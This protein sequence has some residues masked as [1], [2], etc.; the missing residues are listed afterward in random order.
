MKKKIFASVI[1]ICLLAGA[2]VSALAYHKG[3][4]FV[5]KPAA[6][7]TPN[8]PAMMTYNEEE[9]AGLEEMLDVFRKLDSMKAYYF[10]GR[11][12]LTDPADSSQNVS[13]NF[14][15]ARLGDSTYYQLG[16]NRILS[17]PRVY[18]S[19]DDAVKKV[20][21]AGQQEQRT[22]PFRIPTDTLMDQFRMEGYGISIKAV[23]GIKTIRL[24]RENHITCKEYRLAY[25]DRHLIRQLYTR[26]TNLND[27]LNR[28][29]DKET[30]V[31]VDR[32]QQG[33]VPAGLLDMHSFIREVSGKIQPSAS[34]EGYEIVTAF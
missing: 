5:T 1:V 20:F 23:N 26:F 12:S 21:V 17:I 31:T 8:L 10:E 28:S 3:L 13:V 18:I 19:V 32:W 14:R 30:L 22:S 2:L 11:L 27:P 7:P 15:Y 9:M 24:H 16:E 33:S 29:M 4:L 34:L 6:P 25:D